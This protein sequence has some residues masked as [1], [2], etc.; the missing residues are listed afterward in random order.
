MHWSGLIT[1][2]AAILDTTGITISLPG[3]HNLLFEINN[4]NPSF[5]LDDFII[6]IPISIVPNECVKLVDYYIHSSSHD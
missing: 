1:F 4:A 5:L 3:T 2:E 6:D